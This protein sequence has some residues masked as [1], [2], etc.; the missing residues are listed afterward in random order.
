MS[1]SCK[2]KE[3]LYIDHTMLRML[4]QLT[5]TIQRSD[6]CS[7]AQVPTSSAP[8]AFPKTQCVQLRKVTAQNPGP[9]ST[10]Q[11]D[12]LWSFVTCVC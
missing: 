8:K 4:V 10:A 6:E 2:L 11:Q 1:L 3:N 12:M 5:G 9:C 7:D